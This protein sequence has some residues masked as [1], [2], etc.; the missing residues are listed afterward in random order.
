MIDRNIE[1]ALNLRRVQIHEQRAVR[2]GG[3]Q[4]IGDQLRRNGHARTVLAILPGVAVVRNDHRDAAGRGA[5]ERVD[6][7]QQLHQVLVH[8]IA[9]GLHHEY[10]RAADILEQLEVNFAVGK[11]LHLGLA[12]RDADVLADLLRQRAVGRPRK[13]LEALVFAVR[14]RALLFRLS[15]LRRSLRLRLSLRPGPT[16]VMI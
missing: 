1:K 12:Q 6:H 8:R 11:A 10:I 9:G 3:G 16:A 13:D 15:L 5:L 2:A 4:Q 14:P 7:D